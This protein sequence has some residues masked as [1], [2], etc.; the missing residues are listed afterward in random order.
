VPPETLAQLQ[1]RFW[2]LITAPEGVTQGLAEVASDDPGAA[3]VGGWLAARD[4]STVLERLDV[5]A[6]MYFFRL[7]EALRDDVPSV[8]A[9]LGDEGFHNLVVDYLLA[10]PSTDPS[11]RHAG[12]H[13]PGFVSGH[14]AG[15]AHPDLADLARLD[16]ARNDVFDA[17]DSPAIDAAALATIPAEAWPGLRF[18]IAPA[19][20]WL[21][22]RGS[23]L[24]A[25]EALS[26][27][28]TPPA[29]GEERTGCVIWRS[30][31]PG[32]EDQVWHRP[33]SLTELAALDALQ[34][35]ASFERVCE[36]FAAELVA[37]AAAAEAAQP[38]LA[39]LVRWV[40]DGLLSQIDP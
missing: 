18:R 3:P 22:L 25:W 33:A 39:A 36:I 21:R 10:H 7:L 30:R 35:G 23:V 31:A 32:H 26:E 12:R 9:L 14:D 1:R 2:R 15:A 5:Y 24:P 17:A 11:L 20:R 16:L 8:A 29:S 13:L 27:D 37:P 38:A 19:V 6:N 28:R 4:E 34:A 40:S